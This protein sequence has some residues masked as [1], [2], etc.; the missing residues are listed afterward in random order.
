MKE[1]TKNTQNSKTK[2]NLRKKK[3]KNAK[4]C[5]LFC[6]RS[7]ERAIWVCVICV[8]CGWTRRARTPTS[9]DKPFSNNHFL[10]ID[11][12]VS[13]FLCCSC[14]HVPLCLSSAVGPCVFFG[15]AV[16]KLPRSVCINH[17][18]FALV[19]CWFP[20]DFVLRHSV[21]IL[22]IFQPILFIHSNAFSRRLPLTW[23]CSKV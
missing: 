2:W 10:L 21:R 7:S 23:Q 19:F 18:A 17:L 16:C 1:K 8:G 5:G 4:P 6:C 15:R 11:A 22:P 14:V 9:S 12:S 13:V 3:T 20:F